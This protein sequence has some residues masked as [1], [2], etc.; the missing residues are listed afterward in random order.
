MYTRIKIS[1]IIIILY[2]CGCCHNQREKPGLLWDEP[3]H[4]RLM[5]IQLVNMTINMCKDAKWKVRITEGVQESY[6]HTLSYE[7]GLLTSGIVDK[8]AHM[9][10]VYRYYSNPKDYKKSKHSITEIMNGYAVI[11]SDF[12]QLA[13]ERNLYL[14]VIQKEKERQE[15]EDKE[16]AE[17]AAQ[18]PGM[19]E[20]AIKDARAKGIKRPPKDSRRSMNSTTDTESEEKT[21]NVTAVNVN[22]KL[23]KQKKGWSKKNI[24][25]EPE[26][27]KK[28]RRIMFEE[29]WS[30]YD[31]DI[32][33]D[34]VPKSLLKRGLRN[35]SHARNFLMKDL[36]GIL[37]D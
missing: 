35:N 8:F 22:V 19:P 33:G 31:P 3:W 30:G 18:N 5:A 7:I 29:R 17:Y 34:D 6:K 10:R 12:N 9:L 24:S 14:E 15:Q 4:N 23:S 13:I 16:I 37:L 26:Y 11:Q 20:K 2:L 28:L 36:K 21:T 1:H 27:K 25:K 32:E